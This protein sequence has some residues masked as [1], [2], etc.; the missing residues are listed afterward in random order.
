MRLP[1]LRERSSDV[2]K[3]AL[4]ILDHVNASI[5]RPKALSPEALTWLQQQPWPGNVRSLS[6][7]IERSALMTR[8]QTLDVA[9]LALPEP[10]GSSS[11]LEALP[12]PYDGFSLEAVLSEAREHLYRQA[13]NTCAG[14]HSCAARL[15]GVSHEAV[16]KH[17]H[18]AASQGGPSTT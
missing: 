3:I 10:T 9:H 1:A 13:L 7:T 11:W 17:L 14:N 16:R 15:L 6:N 4:H 18:R 2:P 5:R 12:T 8:D